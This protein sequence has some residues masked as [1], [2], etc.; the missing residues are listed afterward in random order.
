MHGTKLRQPDSEMR[1]FWQANEKALANVSV[2]TGQRI[3]RASDHLEL[4]KRFFGT[5]RSRA[6]YK[7]TV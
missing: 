1:D 2:G 6:I 7:T 3:I 5:L 4:L